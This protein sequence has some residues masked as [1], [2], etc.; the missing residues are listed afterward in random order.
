V[1]NIHENVAKPHIVYALMKTYDSFRPRS[2]RAQA[3][4][5]ERE[6]KQ[7]L[8]KLLE[9]DDEETFRAGLEEDFGI[10]PDHPKYAEMLRIW[11]GSR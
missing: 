2:G 11:R 9:V 7:K 4:L 3:R 1:W 10:T 6:L 8:E 5:R